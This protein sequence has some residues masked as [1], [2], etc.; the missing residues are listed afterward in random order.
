MCT[1]SGVTYRVE[2]EFF[3]PC[4]VFRVSEYDDNDAIICMKHFKAD[5]LLRSDE[6]TPFVAALYTYNE[7]RYGRWKSTYTR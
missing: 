7:R 3:P 6:L 5:E 2:V 4:E 1:S